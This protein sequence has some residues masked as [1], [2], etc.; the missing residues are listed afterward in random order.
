MALADSHVGFI[1]KTLADLA[2]GWLSLAGKSSDKNVDELLLYEW[3][4]VEPLENT[5]KRTTFWFQT[6]I[7]NPNHYEIV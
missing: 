6:L 2:L 5:G 7:Q 1:G 3:S 4:A